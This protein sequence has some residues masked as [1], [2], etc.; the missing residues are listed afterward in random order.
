M[1][2]TRDY[3]KVGQSDYILPPMPSGNLGERIGSNNEV[4]R[5]AG[6]PNFLNRV[7]GIALARTFFQPRGH[8]AG[9]GG[10]GQFHH[11]VTILITGAG[12]ID[13]M[14]RVR[15]GYEQHLLELKLVRSFPCH[16]EVSVVNGVEGSPEQSD[17]QSFILILRS[18]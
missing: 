11:P 8:K 18:T 4:R 12:Q 2:R 7:D 9:I 3:Y 14:R 17:W 5:V 10:A 6:R 13:F 16:D 15:G 1:A